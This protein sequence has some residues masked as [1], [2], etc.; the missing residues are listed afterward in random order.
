MKLSVV[1]CCIGI[2]LSA[3][4]S[5]CGGSGTLSLDPVASAADK[6]ASAGSAKVTV[7]MTLSKAGKTLS[8]PGSGVADMKTGDAD[9]TFDFSQISKLAGSQATGT[10]A[11]EITKGG[12]AYLKMPFTGLPA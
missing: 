6:T 8:V 2:G 4:V 11:E 5:G 7:A 3:I 1:I 12:I 9:I 10:Q